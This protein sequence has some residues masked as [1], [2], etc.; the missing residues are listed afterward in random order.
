MR[1]NR[2]IARVLTLGLLMS[3]ALMIAGLALSSLRG[4][5][6]IPQTTSWTFLSADLLRLDPAALMSLGILVLLLTPVLRLTAL[7]FA[8]LRKGDW[9]FAALAGFV[10]AVLALSVRLGMQP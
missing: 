2:V 8:Y 3:L 6:G 5:A 1:L 9:L 4:G 10:L 7:L